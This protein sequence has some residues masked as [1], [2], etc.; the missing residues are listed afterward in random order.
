MSR[1][2]ARLFLAIIAFL[3]VFA[4]ACGHNVTYYLDRGHQRF[5]SGD[6][7][8]AVLEY[9]KAIQKDPQFAEAHYQI[10]RA[11]AK[12]GQFREAYDSLQRAEQ[13]VP[14]RENIRV[15]LGNLILAAYLGDPNHPQPLY[16]QLKRISTQLLARNPKSA[17][18]I[19][20]QGELTLTDR[21]L[22]EAAALFQQAN[23]IRPMDPAIVGPW[24][25]TLLKDGQ[26][27]EGEKLAWQLIDSKKS[28]S[29]IYEVLYAHYMAQKRYAEGESVVQARIRNNPGDVNSVL[30]LGFHYHHLNQ[31]AQML[32]TLQRI[33]DDP[34]TYPQGHLHVA[35][36]Y[37]NVSM[38][39]EALRELHTGIKTDPGNKTVYLS[40]IAGIQVAQK[41]I[42]DAT[43][44]VQEMLKE[45]PHDR[46]ARAMRAILLLDSG[47]PEKLD[48][49]ISEM[50][51]LLKE[52]NE[53]ATL[54]YSLGRAQMA[55]A[56]WDAARKELQEAIRIRGNDVPARLALLQISANSNS[57]PDV[58][59]YSGEILTL[60]PSNRAARFW[61][62]VARMGQGNYDQARLDLTR[63]QKEYPNSKD[64][65]L[66]LGLLA[67]K[68]KRFK[69]AESIFRKSYE[70][71]SSD[72]RPLEGLVRTYV[73]Q[74][75][76][77]NALLAAQAEVKN[78][79][80]SL[81]AHA[82]LAAVASVSGKSTLAIEQ[83]QW[84][85]AR[86]PKNPAR[87]IELAEA[88]QAAGEMG[89]ALDAFQQARQLAPSD[90]RVV[91]AI[92]F[93]QD[94]AG[95]RAEAKV[96]Y[97]LALQM[98]PGNASILNN[99]AYLLADTKDN[100]DD[101][102]RLIKDA[103]H[104]APADPGIADTLAWIYIQKNYNEGALQILN[105]LLKEHPSDSTYRYH[106]AV[107]CLQSGD[108]ARAKQELE[109]ALSYKPEKDT[110]A[111]IKALIA[112]IG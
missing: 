72:A 19:R 18:G 41:R 49:G 64:V 32:G 110:A 92:A 45:K 12:L 48:L 10:G 23:A 86:D 102:L 37:S 40:R 42:A 78:S 2:K 8:A 100:L 99:L 101:A 73:A 25:E 11:L 88:F 58:L 33:L 17:D 69:E 90:G 107:A 28:F 16:D 50:T 87:H 39:D 94:A 54:H 95:Q 27:Q 112:R 53:D 74:D 71:S 83:R 68:E 35:E 47:R 38:P 56:N 81:P 51:A 52:N 9:R 36:F 1:D 46:D 77:D 82:L 29:L 34:K 24:V 63:L 85:A 103:Q 79:P 66:Q 89:R 67:L 111:R 106:L 61:T 7:A 57:Y 26:Y 21:K 59:R 104:Q 62:A 98:D 108:R 97:Q 5:A 75:D 76:L 22:S 60:D 93:L 6:N 4:L 96:N 109:I 70:P 91:A 15:E 44:T 55:K 80:G 13:L 30:Q 31:N 20:F 43:E 84:L 14:N 3:A 65:L 105:K